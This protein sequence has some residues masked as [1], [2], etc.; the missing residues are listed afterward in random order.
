MKRKQRFSPAVETPFS[1]RALARGLVCLALLMAWT[2]VRAQEVPPATAAPAAAPAAE[3][4]KAAPPAQESPAGLR[5]WKSATG[6]EII[7]EF[8]EVKNGAVLLKDANGAVRNIRLVLL[9]AEDQKLAQE[10]QQQK[11]AAPSASAT[12]QTASD[13]LPVFT[14]GPH[15]DFHAVYTC[16]NFVARMRPDTTVDIQC[17]ENGKPAGKPIRLASYHAYHEPKQNRTVGRRI[18]SFDKVSEPTLTPGV[19]YFEGMLDDQ[20]KFGVG[21]EF[22]ANTV[23]AWGWV[24]DPPG[25]DKPTSYFRYFSIP[26]LRTFEAHVPVAEQK[27]ILEPYSINVKPA[28]GKSID[29]PYGDVVKG[30]AS[31]ASQVTVNGPVF[32]KR[33]ISFTPG[34]AKE[35]TL[36]PWIYPSF[37]PYQGYQVRLRKADKAFRS[38]RCRIILTVN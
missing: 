25:I 21:V 27:K 17:M 23:Q 33:M 9:S 35:G 29:Y 24:E 12:A 28:K 4:G 36:Q 13:R 32:E 3:A 10:L 8:L 38:D 31:G 22:K 6:H 30:W 14:D 15:K 18:V 16:P 26:D 20:V 19:L 1:L 11:G 7:A 37:A 5:A 2:G 34:T